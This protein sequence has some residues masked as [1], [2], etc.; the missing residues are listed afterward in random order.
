LQ[1]IAASEEESKY[2]G[3]DAADGTQASI[4]H[5]LLFRSLG[6]FHKF[7]KSHYYYPPCFFI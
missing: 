3:G 5:I 7:L 4:D 2:E 1:Q 6:S